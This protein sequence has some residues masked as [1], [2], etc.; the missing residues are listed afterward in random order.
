M[1]TQAVWKWKGPA[2]GEEDVAKLRPVRPGTE[3]ALLLGVL[4]MTEQPR[5]AIRMKDAVRKASII[6]YLP[7]E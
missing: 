1:T 7:Q 6:N 2:L 5:S 4:G 3:E